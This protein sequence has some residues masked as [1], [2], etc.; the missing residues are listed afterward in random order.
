MAVKI[1]ESLVLRGVRVNPDVRMVL[2]RIGSNLSVQEP[3]A[4]SLS[5]ARHL[6]PSDPQADGDAGTRGLTACT[7][8]VKRPAHRAGRPGS[9]AGVLDSRRLARSA[10]R[11]VLCGR[12]A[13]GS[14]GA[15]ATLTTAWPTGSQAGM[16]RPSMCGSLICS[17]RSSGVK[18][19]IPPVWHQ[20]QL[21]PPYYGNFTSY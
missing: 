5:F 14:R 4:V 6:F 16:R 12:Q 18:N 19:R 9:S 10:R 13:V 3:Q 20:P 2:E 17:P 15:L 8:G 11:A 1:L 21:R 7:P